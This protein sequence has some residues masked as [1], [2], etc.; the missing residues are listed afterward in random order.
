MLAGRNKG[1][2]AH[3]RIVLGR[4]SAYAGLA[5]S[6]HFMVV[7]SVARL[8]GLLL[9]CAI[10][11][12]PIAVSGP[13]DGASDAGYSK[14]GADTCLK[15][16]DEDY[17]YPVVDIFYTKH[18]RQDD[19]RAP[20]AGLQCEACH[21]PA[22]AHTQK[23]MPGETRPPPPNTFGER[24]ATRMEQQNGACLQCHEDTARIHWKGSTHEARQLACA[25]CHLIHAVQDPV[26]QRQS[27]SDVCFRCHKQQRSL[28]IAIKSK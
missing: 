26:L 11:G 19:P 2:L 12:V 28:V 17:N 24:A 22:K 20:F 13:N 16:H 1:M 18:A 25:S 15:C 5:I 23:V 7:A 6:G 3:R 9:I 4:H 8:A 14:H 21:G 10:P 27:Q